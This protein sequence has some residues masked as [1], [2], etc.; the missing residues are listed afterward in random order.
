MGFWVTCLSVFVSLL[1]FTE[2][3]VVVFIFVLV[4]VALFRKFHSLWCG[5]AHHWILGVLVQEM[6]GHLTVSWA[7]GHLLLW[8]RTEHRS[9]VCCVVCCS[10][11]GRRMLDI[12]LRY[13][14]WHP[15]VLTWTS[16]HTWCW[17]TE[18]HI[19]SGLYV[20]FWIQR[21]IQYIPWCWTS[22]T[23]GCWWGSVEK[24]VK[25]HFLFIHGGEWVPIF[26]LG[27]DGLLNKSQKLEWIIACACSVP[28]RVMLHLFHQY[29]GTLTSHH[30]EGL[31]P[32]FI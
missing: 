3:L 21:R 25:Y 22:H 12:F 27:Q 31:Y 28:I 13:I 11:W 32:L 17:I 1:V 8:S 2:L 18:R 24:I 4:P 5:L 15:L 14:P 7:C 19:W 26:C 29:L 6:E 20:V 30:L 10:A 9:S 23:I 16:N